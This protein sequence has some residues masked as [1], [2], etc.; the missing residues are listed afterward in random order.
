MDKTIGVIGLG[1]MGAPMAEE[2]LKSGYSVIAFDT[3][4]ERLDAVVRLGGLAATS[5]KDVAD[6][7]AVVLASLPH[8]AASRVVAL[9][10]DGIIGG[11]ACKYFIET[12]TIGVRAS[13]EIS[14]GLSEAGV[15]FVDA[16]VSG[17]P[18]AI[19]NR[20]L[21]AMVSAQESVL[22]DLDEILQVLCSKRIVVG[23]EA[24][25]AQACKLVNN[26]ISLSHLQIAAE[27]MVFGVKAG[28]DAGVLLE[29]INSSSGR[30]DTTLKKFPV[31]VLTRSFDYGASLATGAK[32]TALFVDEAREMGLLLE[33][34]PAIAESWRTAAQ[35]D[36]ERDFTEII[37]K[38]ESVAGVEVCNR[39]SGSQPPL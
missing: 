20:S 11:Q 9:G 25:L 2:F 5:P 22:S 21:T 38:F 10:S 15:T 6:R 29:V 7:T 18:R 3:V 17:G 12:S 33:S 8:G 31:A 26:A 32:D 16:P 39:P 23:A 24:G 19:R 14:E 35:T 34:L 28:V 37:K 13:R 30:S 1:L 27:T 36:P 4:P